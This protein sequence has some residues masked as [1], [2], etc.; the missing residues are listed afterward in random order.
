M[1]FLSNR[2]LFLA[3]F[4]L[5]IILINVSLFSALRKNKSG[6]T[7]QILKNSFSSVKDPFKKENQELEELSQLVNTLEEKNKTKF[8]NE[9][10]K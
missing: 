8:N 4:I 3:I 7:L 9:E 1:D 10:N 6:T 2:E 5:A